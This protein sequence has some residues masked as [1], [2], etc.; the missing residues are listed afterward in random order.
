MIELGFVRKSQILN[1]LADK[2]SHPAT[3]Q[4]VAARYRTVP[5]QFAARVG[6]PIPLPHPE[7]ST[8]SPPLPPSV[9]TLSSAHYWQSNFHLVKL[10]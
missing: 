5:Y 4:E 9:G 2:V 1:S 3:V 7:S 10:L 6:P 8:G